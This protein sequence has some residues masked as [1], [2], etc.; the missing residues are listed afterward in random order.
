MFDISNSAE[1]KEASKL[2][3]EG[4]NV[5]TNALYDH[6]A[7]LFVKEYNMLAFPISISTGYKTAIYGTQV[8]KITPQEGIQEVGRIVTDE[9]GQDW[10]KQVDR[11]VRINDNLYNV[12]RSRIIANNLQT[13]KETN[14]V[15]F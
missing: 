10:T 13:L 1:P 4:Q 14:R 2:V 8:V 12:C 7:F 5:Y 11:I 6:K 15:D 3:I 9:K